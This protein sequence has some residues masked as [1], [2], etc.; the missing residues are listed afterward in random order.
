[1]PCQGSPASSASSAPF[2]RTCPQRQSVRKSHDAAPA[3]A[4]ATAE[5]EA[6]HRRRAAKPGASVGTTEVKML[7]VWLE[8]FE[9]HLNFPVCE[10]LEMTST[11]QD[12]A[13]GGSI[14]AEDRI[15]ECFIIFIHSLK[16]GLFRVHLK[17]PQTRIN[18]ATP[19]VDG[20]V[21]SR[22]ILGPM[23]RYTAL[24]MAKR[25]RLDL[26]SYQLPHVRRKLKIQELASRYRAD[27]QTPEFYT[28]LFSPP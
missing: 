5:P 12:G 22:R 6:P 23:V 16:S 19:L 20:M 26:D 4:A 3:A 17:G 21:V 1:M 28:R 7:A 10:L 2:H 24:N 15:Q 13:A 18:L 27:L 25:R 11:G 9:D 8:S 14:R